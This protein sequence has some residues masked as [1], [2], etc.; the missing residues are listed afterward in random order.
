MKMIPDNPEYYDDDEGQLTA[1]LVVAL[2][3]RG[4]PRS[5]SLFHQAHYAAFPPVLRVPD[6]RRRLHR[7]GRM[8]VTNIMCYE[9]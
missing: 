4:M 1:P 9:N 5:I 8:V 2:D 7:T 6:K 3:D